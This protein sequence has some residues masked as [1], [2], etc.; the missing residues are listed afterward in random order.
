VVVTEGGGSDGRGLTAYQQT[1]GAHGT[2]TKSAEQPRASWVTVSP[3]G[4]SA[5]LAA[6]AYVAWFGAARTHTAPAVRDAAAPN[7]TITKGPP[8]KTHSHAVTFRFRSSEAGSVFQCRSN[9]GAWVGC[10]SGWKAPYHGKKAYRVEI[11]AIDP[12][13]NV[14]GSPATRRYLVD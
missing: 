12:A 6:A 8:A 4:H 13:G 10:R 9:S 1:V 14:D 5:S 2:W 3:D 7:T 11:R